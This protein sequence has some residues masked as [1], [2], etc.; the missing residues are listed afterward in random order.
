M[1]NASLLSIA[2]SSYETWGKFQEQGY[3]ISARTDCTYHIAKV[4]GI[5]ATRNDGE[6]GQICLRLGAEPGRGVCST[7]GG[8]SPEEAPSPSGAHINRLCPS[9]S[10]QHIARHRRVYLISAARC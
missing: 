1:K 2:M 5:L 6:L 8:E 7:A 4:I 9:T 3:R 10:G